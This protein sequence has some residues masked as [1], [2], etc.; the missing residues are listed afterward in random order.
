MI[1]RLMGGLGNQMFQYAMGKAAA[2]ERNE[3]L[4]LDRFSY[5]RDKKRKCEIDKFNIKSDSLNV[6]QTLYY[7]MLFWKDRKKRKGNKIFWERNIFEFDAIKNISSKY[8]VGSWQNEKYFKELKN[9]L[10][11]ELTFKERFSAAVEEK[12]EYI[13]Q[14]NSVA[15]HVRHGD[16]LENSAYVIQSADYYIRAMQYVSAK[17]EDAKFYF[18]SDDIKWCKK[19]FGQQKNVIYI[20]ENTDLEDFFLMCKCRHFIIAN[21]TFSWWAAW[22]A[23]TDAMKISP[24]NWFT[25]KNINERVKEALLK[26]FYAL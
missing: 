12:A 22:L 21:S 1:V 7:N 5:I 2:K 3:K 19:Q 26:E 14:E 9:E 10:R 13:S 4:Y 25:D 8:F 20:S 16:Y 17:Y 15:V 23:D 11:G 6:E 24:V 18:F